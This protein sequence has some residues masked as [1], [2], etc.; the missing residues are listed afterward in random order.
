MVRPFLRWIVSALALTTSR[1]HQRAKKVTL[2]RIQAHSSNGGTTNHVTK[3]LGA[4]RIS[5]IPTFFF[6]LLSCFVPRGYAAE[7][8]AQKPA[9]ALYLQLGSV[10][11]DPARVYQV[12]EAS[13]DRPSIHITLE[14][15]TLAFTQDVMGR[16]TGAFFEGD[17]EIL[18]I[19]PNEVERKSMSL[20]TGMAILEERF[21]TAYF[22]FND[23]VVTEL[24]PDLRAAT[25]QQEFAERSGPT[26]KNLANADAMRL[27]VSFSRM[28]P[29]GDGSSSPEEDPQRE[30]H[31]D[32]F[33]HARLHGT[34]LGVF[35][36]YFDST[37]PEEVLVGQAKNAENGDPYYDVWTSFSA[38]ET[39][40]LRHSGSTIESEIEK[41]P[42][43]RVTVRSYKIRTEVLPPKQIQAKAS[44]QCEVGSGGA[45]TLMFELSRFLQID[46]VTLDGKPV[47]FIHNP[48]LGGT[49]LARQG[50][51]VVAVILPRTAR[52]GEKFELQFVYG[53]EV[54]AEAG[55]GLFYVG[56][57]GTWYPNRG[58][59]MANFDLEFSYPSGWT[60]LATGK[61]APVVAGGDSAEAPGQQHSRWIS[62][63]PIPLAGFNLG[64]YRGAITH[65]GQV[66][67]ETYATAGVEK[68][69]PSASIQVVGPT[70]TDAIPRSSQVIVPS[71]PSPAQ[72]EVIVGEAA[73]QAIEYFAARFGSFP[74]SHL[75][76]TQMPGRESEG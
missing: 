73:A 49:Q 32:H 3:V 8:P 28:L 71:L 31:S 39:K 1:A 62:D 14:D 13:L 7:S 46:S 54:L 69:F 4:Q 23:D 38:A 74:Y 6:L 75:A 29:S 12:R 26:A 17:G 53:G 34:K 58:L 56:A 72:H 19:P 41:V 51:D 36:V 43:H 68:S 55:S 10:G 47:E 20:F 64:K 40:P 5:W 24:G 15:G 35:D 30:N 44:L 50:N 76:L 45:R 61:P 16:V 33:L 25:N 67:V 66:I 42:G 18:L 37:A 65:A 22:R 48:A 57:R 52:A 2:G 11:I 70:S 59:D 21:A 63:R 27:L 9:E 60:L